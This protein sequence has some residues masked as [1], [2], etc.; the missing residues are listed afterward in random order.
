M[1]EIF[2]FVYLDI[3]PR[4]T[5][6]CRTIIPRSLPG[7]KIGRQMYPVPI[8]DQESQGWTSSPILDQ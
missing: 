5:I 3:F 1:H 6:G 2:G 7:E 8:A 4:D